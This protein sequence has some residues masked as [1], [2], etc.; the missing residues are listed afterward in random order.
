LLPACWFD[1]FMK[2][3]YIL[4]GIA[5]LVVAGA[6]IYLHRGHQVPPGQAPLQNLTAQNLAGIR[7]AFNAD[8]NQARVLALLSPT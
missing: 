2:R 3:K 4:A 7:A 8:G 1:E 5:V 6:T